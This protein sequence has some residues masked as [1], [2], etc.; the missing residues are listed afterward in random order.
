MRLVTD[1]VNRNSFDLNIPETI[2]NPGQFPSDALY[3]TALGENWRW[4]Y[5]AFHL[6][7]TISAGL[8]LKY[9]SGAMPSFRSLSLIHSGWLLIALLIS[10]VLVYYWGRVLGRSRAAGAVSAAIY[11][12]PYLVFQRTVHACFPDNIQQALLLA[13]LTMAPGAVAVPS[14]RRIFALSAL[15]GAVFGTKYLGVFILPLI[16][17]LPAL[18]APGRRQWLTPRGLA[19]LAALMTSGFILGFAFSSPQALI[20]P[21]FFVRSF[22]DI[23]HAINYAPFFSGGPV[24]AYLKLIWT[25]FLNGDL[26]LA[27]FIACGS[28]AILA[29]AFGPNQG[30]ESPF[31]IT[32]LLWV[33]IYS[34]VLAAKLRYYDAGVFYPVWPFMAVGA[35]VAFPFLARVCAGFFYLKDRRVEAVFMLVLALFLLRHEF[36]ANPGAVFSPVK[37]DRPLVFN[38]QNPF[39]KGVRDLSGFLEKRYGGGV[40]ILT[41]YSQVYI[42]PE[43]RHVTYTAFV[44]MGKIPEKELSA[45]KAIILTGSDKDFETAVKEGIYDKAMLAESRKIYEKIRSGTGFAKVAE[46]DYPPGWFNSKVEVWERR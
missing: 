33:L 32:A 24:P 29:K 30:N 13:C 19:M 17:I 46:F 27:A 9:I 8:A 42:P 31:M 7:L 35:G 15:A 41:D 25:G 18:S 20:W 43:I 37:T 6:N 1:C 39:F 21:G 16:A 34:C 36:I 11:V 45:Y 3:G 10:Q 26:L 14:A 44:F 5:G 40:P 12:L 4:G 23:V 22:R 2:A 38:I 28:L